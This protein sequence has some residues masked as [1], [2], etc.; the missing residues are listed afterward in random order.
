MET[1]YLTVAHGKLH[2]SPVLLGTRDKR[3]YVEVLNGVSDS[4][5]VLLQ[6]N[7]GGLSLS[8]AQRVR[9]SLVTTAEADRR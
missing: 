5:R 6:A 4:Q 2:L 3:G 8:D 9:A 1:R 7:A